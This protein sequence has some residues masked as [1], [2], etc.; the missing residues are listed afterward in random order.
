MGKDHVH[1]HRYKASELFSCIAGRV[2]P[3]RVRDVYRHKKRDSCDYID[4]YMGPF[5]LPSPGFKRERRNS[6]EIPN[7]RSGTSVAGTVLVA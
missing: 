7:P 3:T 6:H 4:T 2:L 5:Q 1:F